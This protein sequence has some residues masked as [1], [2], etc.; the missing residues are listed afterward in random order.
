MPEYGIDEINELVKVEAIRPFQLPGLSSH[1]DLS[2]KLASAYEHTR[3]EEVPV[4]SSDGRKKVRLK[5][6]SYFCQIP[7]YGEPQLR[8]AKKDSN[9]ASLHSVIDSDDLDIDDANQAS[10]SMVAFSAGCQPS[11]TPT[12]CSISEPSYGLSNNRV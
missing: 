5:S 9:I 4:G 1:Q 7:R 12:Y 8:K 10:S 11:S 3:N 6:E 2:V